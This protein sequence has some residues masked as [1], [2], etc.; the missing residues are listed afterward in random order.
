MLV[1]R[2][3]GEENIDVGG[4]GTNLFHPVWWW[5]NAA[6]ASVCDATASL[7]AMY[8]GADVPV[9][10]GL[11]NRGRTRAQPFQGHELPES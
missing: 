9:L 7:C 10:L 6:W 8:S 4:T 2:V 11:L 1:I 5:R 3:K